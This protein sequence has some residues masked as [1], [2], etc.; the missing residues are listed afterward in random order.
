MLRR[1][2]FP[3]NLGKIGKHGVQVAEVENVVR[4]AKRPYPRHHKTVSWLVLGNAQTGR[5]FEVVFG[6]SRPDEVCDSCHTGGRKM[7][8]QAETLTFLQKP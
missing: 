8:D 1:M 5:Y 3:W 6:G 7:Q 4:F 2:E